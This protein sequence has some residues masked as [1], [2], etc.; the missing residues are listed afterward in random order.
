MVVDGGDE[1]WDLLETDFAVAQMVRWSS[2]R[3]IQ[4]VG[5]TAA[6]SIELE[7]AESS[8]QLLV[9]Q[10]NRCKVPTNDYLNC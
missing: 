10:R 3:S 2:A 8:T 1:Q 5:Q 9:S 7:K 6:C 4:G